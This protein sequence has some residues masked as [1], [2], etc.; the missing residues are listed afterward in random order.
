MAAQKTHYYI[1]IITK[2]EMN[3]EWL[4]MVVLKCRDGKRKK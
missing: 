1:Q 4:E 3:Q 2:K